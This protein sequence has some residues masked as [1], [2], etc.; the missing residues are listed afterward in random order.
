MEQAKPAPGTSALEAQ[1]I[2]AYV[3]YL[4][5]LLMVVNTIN[6]MD[7]HVLSILI[8]AIK[9]D[10][11]ISDSQIG[12]LIGLAFA[13]FYATC[14]IP[15][16][17]LADRGVRKTIIATCLGV[18]SVSTALGGAAQ[19]F[20]HLLLSRIGVGAAEAGYPASWQSLI[21]DYVPPLRRPTVFAV[22][23]L[24]VMFGA[25]AGMP[26][27]GQ[28][29]D[30]VGWRWTLVILGLPGALV[31]LVVAVTVREPPRGRFDGAASSTPVSLRP[32]LTL[33]SH[34]PAF[35]LVVV[36]HVLFGFFQGFQ[37]WIP[38]FYQ[39][40]HG[41][42]LAHVGS[43]LGLAVGVGTGL[44][45]ITGGW[46]ASL[47]SRE[48]LHRPLLVCAGA[49]VA[50][51]ALLVMALFVADAQLSMWLVGAV[52]LLLSIPAPMVLAAL[53]GSVSPN[54]RATAAAICIFAFAAVGNTLGPLVV[55]VL[56]DL[57]SP[58]VGAGALRFAMLAPLTVLP[59]DALVFW[60]LARAIRRQGQG[61][62]R[63]RPERRSR[64][65][66][67]QQQEPVVARP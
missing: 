27:A 15:I 33:L 12:L 9:T 20:V 31:A 54:V 17:R 60:L 49:T 62:D 2:S 51:V 46:V 67:D 42:D 40:I 28:L 23:S 66:A 65:G 53:H 63:R 58:E 45:I 44:G 24:G 21:C 38:T 25:L 8:P 39:R 48:G 18:W 50:A 5:G 14:S 30:S 61:S 56:S 52:F 13:L 32:A 34:S 64:L 16:A 29:G 37:Q 19:N 55:G 36:H 10:L 6:Y 4:V 11:R 41:L 35:A 22:I 57:L 1:P 43:F 7:R 26:L 3:W 47:W 59:L